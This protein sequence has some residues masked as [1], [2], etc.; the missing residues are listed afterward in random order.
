MLPDGSGCAFVMNK[1]VDDDTYQSNIYVQLF[2]EA[3]TV[4]PWTFGTNQNKSPRFS[5]DGEQMVLGADRSG[6]NQLWLINTSGGE[7]EQMTTFKNGV[8]STHCSPDISKII[9]ITRLVPCT[10]GQEQQK[11]K[12]KEAVYSDRLQYKAEGTG[13]KDDKKTQIIMYDIYNKTFQQLTTAKDDHYFQDI[14]PDN[15]RILFLANLDEDSDYT[16]RNDLYELEF[17]NNDIKK[18]T[19]EK[20]DYNKANYSPD[21]EKIVLIGNER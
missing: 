4:T 13:L 1:A 6:S 10:N 11:D 21:G 5:P 17:A 18:L 8:F 7:D 2:D 19:N 3:K 15:K 20:H 14:S 9:I 12:Q 16:L